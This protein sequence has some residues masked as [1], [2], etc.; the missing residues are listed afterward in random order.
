MY[1][2]L[3]QHELAELCSG[4]LLFPV[5]YEP[6]ADKP[7]P[8]A[9]H[10]NIAQCGPRNVKV[11]AKLTAFSH[12]TKQCL[13]LR[14]IAFV[15]F[16]HRCWKIR[17]FANWIRF[18]VRLEVFKAVTMKNGVFWDVTPCGSCKNRRIGGT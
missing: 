1:G 13:P 4:D 18:H 16:V 15:S 6:N 7:P 2:F 5:R 17:R 10:G 14:I 11:S 3:K 9:L 8:P 12:N